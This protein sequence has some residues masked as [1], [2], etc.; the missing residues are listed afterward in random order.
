MEKHAAHSAAKKNGIHTME[1]HAARSA[2]K[3]KLDT[4]VQWKNTPRAARRGKI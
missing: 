2:A 1:K 4:Y 3:K